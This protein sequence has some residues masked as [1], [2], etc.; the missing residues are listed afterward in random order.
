MIFCSANWAH[1]FCMCL[2]HTAKVSV[3]GI[4]AVW[5]LLSV[6]LISID[7]GIGATLMSARSVT[8]DVVNDDNLLFSS[9]RCFRTEWKGQISVQCFPPSF[10]SPDLRWQSTHCRAH[11]FP[12]TPDHRWPHAVNS[13]DLAH[14]HLMHTLFLWC[15][16]LLWVYWEQYGSLLWRVSPAPRSLCRLKCCSGSG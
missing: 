11:Q 9:F 6:L 5:I 8:S 2:N 15:V 12:H 13:T 7:I 14:C 10:V 1:S 3:S 16:L 4:R